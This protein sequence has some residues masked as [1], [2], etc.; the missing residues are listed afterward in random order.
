MATVPQTD[1]AQEPEPDHGS[2]SGSGPGPHAAR[3]RQ[4]HWHA[5]LVGVVGRPWK[6]YKK[7]PAGARSTDDA[8]EP[9]VHPSLPGT[10]PTGLRRLL[11]HIEPLSQIARAARF[12]PA[13]LAVIVFAAIIVVV[14]GLLSLPIA[15]TSGERSDFLDAL[16]TATSAVCVTGLST[17]DTATYWSTFGHV[18]IILAAAV[19]GLGVMTLASLLSLAVSRHVGLTQRMLAASENQSRL[20]EVGHLLR[21]VIYT[22]AGCELLLTLM[23]LPRF[24]GHGLDVGHAL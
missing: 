9:P 5:P 2:R 18:V 13:R 20:G 10:E 17:V 23:L 6:R 8:D 22:A 11:R 1:T 12:Y 19:G 4:A 15:T 7:H 24:L 3:Q 21:A 14:T 16:F